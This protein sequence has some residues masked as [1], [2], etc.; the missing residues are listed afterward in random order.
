[1]S[2]QFEICLFYEF[3]CVLLCW[4][5]LESSLRFLYIYHLS[6][7][8]LTDSPKR[9]NKFRGLFNTLAAMKDHVGG[10]MRGKELVSICK[11]P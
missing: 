11:P 9:D 3:L 4:I 8:G 2:D 1:M 10:S 7:I 5:S 6:H